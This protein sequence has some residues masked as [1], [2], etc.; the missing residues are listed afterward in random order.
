MEVDHKVPRSKAGTSHKRNL[1]LLCPRCNKFKGNLSWPEAI[2]KAK[3]LGI[4]KSD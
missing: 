1:Q 3:K 2:D 4:C